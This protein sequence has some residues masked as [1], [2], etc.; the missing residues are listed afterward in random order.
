MGGVIELVEVDTAR[1]LAWMSITGISIRS[2]FRLRDAGSGGTKVTFRPAY[3]SPGGLLGL[4]ADLLTSRQVGHTLSASHA[5]LHGLVEAYD[6][7]RRARPVP[8]AVMIRTVTS[9]GGL[10][11]RYPDLL[12]RAAWRFCFSTSASCS[13]RSAWARLPAAW[14]RMD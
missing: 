3:Q 6:P 7:H 1:H 10:R 14:L 2:R 13:T 11:I 4:L 9:I 12:A 8:N 5:N